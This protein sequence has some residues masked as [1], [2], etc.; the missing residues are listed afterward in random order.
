MWQDENGW[1]LQFQIQISL[2]SLDKEYFLQSWISVNHIKRDTQ[3]EDLHVYKKKPFLC[4]FV[5]SADMLKKINV[6][7]TDPHEA[8][9]QCQISVYWYSSFSLLLHKIQDKVILVYLQ[10]EFSYICEV[11]GYI[12]HLLYFWDATASYPGSSVEAEEILNYSTTW[13]ISLILRMCLQCA[14][15][16]K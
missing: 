5:F 10:R 3:S 16:H 13:I 11:L 6:M 12:F 15:R 14:K 1:L 4:Y 2:F 7:S 9:N 8:W